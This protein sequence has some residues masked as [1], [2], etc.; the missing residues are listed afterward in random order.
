GLGASKCRTSAVAAGNGVTDAVL[1]AGMF[2]RVISVGKAGR[3][4]PSG[5]PLRRSHLDAL[6]GEA[7]EI[8]RRI[9]RI[10]HFAVEEGLLAARGRGRDIGGR[11][12]E[13]LCGLAPEILAI[14]LAHERL[15]VGRRLELAPTNVL[16]E[17]PEV[18]T[19]E[20]IGGVLAP[21]LH[22]LLG[23]FFDP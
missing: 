12:R 5:G 3:G 14:D 7:L 15:G 8:S 4:R 6:D 17:E 1:R 2:M 23:A 16:G 22:V 20:W 21:E 13:R 9:L 11:H 10:E 18:V 19:L